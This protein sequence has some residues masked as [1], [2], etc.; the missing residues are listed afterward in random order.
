MSSKKLKKKRNQ[1]LKQLLALPKAAHDGDEATVA[2]LLARGVDANAAPANGANQHTALM[3][4]AMNGHGGCVKLL[5]DGGAAVNQRAANASDDPGGGYNALMLAAI[6]GHRDVCTQLLE[7]GADYW[8]V[9]GGRNSRNAL[10]L[11]TEII[12]MAKDDFA[13]LNPALRARLPKCRAV[14]EAWLLEHGTEQEKA[15]LLC[16]V[17]ETGMEARASEILSRSVDLSY[18]DVAAKGGCSAL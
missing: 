4:A 2:G 9:S 5:L 11:C 1:E 18:I 10:E 7:A 8:Q 13:K 17:V 3:N 12:S 14:L 6:G 16:S 15:W